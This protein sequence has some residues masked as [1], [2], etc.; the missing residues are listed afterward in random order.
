MAHLAIRISLKRWSPCGEWPY[1]AREKLAGGSRASELA[2][3]VDEARIGDW[4]FEG[5]KGDPEP[6]TRTPDGEVA[7]KTEDARDAG[8]KVSFITEYGIAI[9]YD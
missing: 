3:D 7:E 2:R 4:R 8:A 6:G 9:S 1:R 5:Q